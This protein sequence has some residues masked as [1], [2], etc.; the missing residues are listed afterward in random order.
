MLPKEMALI[1]N[2]VFP[3]DAVTKAL[4]RATRFGR[5][6]AADVPAILAIGPAASDPAPAG[7]RVVVD[8][9]TAHVRS[10]DAYAME[11]FDDA[12]DH[13]STIHR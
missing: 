7:D 10:F 8:L 11:K 9:P 2:E 6:R 5:F 3:A 1:V 13:L 4:T 12:A